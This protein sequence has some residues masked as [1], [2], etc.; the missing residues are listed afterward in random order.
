[1]IPGVSEYE[2]KNSGIFN[3]MYLCLNKELY[4]PQDKTKLP[5]DKYETG[6]LFY[7]NGNPKSKDFNSLA[8]FYISEDNIEI[9]IPWQLLN[10]MDPSSKTAMDDLYKGEI[11]GIKINGINSGIILIRDEK[12]IEES[13]MAMYSWKEWEEPSYHERLKPSYYILKEAFKKIGEY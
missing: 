4:L 2:K 3:P 7:G 5:L 6:K 8:D 11:K 12:V 13:S 1:M 10:I 9:R